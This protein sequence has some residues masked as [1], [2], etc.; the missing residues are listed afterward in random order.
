M[1]NSYQEQVN[2]AEQAINQI[3]TK[4]DVLDKKI[5]GL[6][7]NLR[8]VGKALT[9]SGQSDQLKKQ[10]EQIKLLNTQLQKQEEQTKKLSEAEKKSDQLKKRRE[11]QIKRESDL[12]ERLHRQKVREEKENFNN[13]VKAA[14]ARKKLTSEEKKS[15]E[16]N[17][18]LIRSQ[19]NLKRAYVRLIN[20]QNNAKNKLRDLIVTGKKATQTQR[21]H[22]REVK[23]AQR[24]FDRYTRKLN[25]ANKATS[26][27]SKNGLGRML[28]GFRNLVGGFGIILGISLLR[29]FTRAVFENLKVLDKLN[30]SL[31]AVI[32]NEGELMRTRAFLMD[33]SIRFGAELVSTTERYIK[34]QVAARQSG[35][36]LQKTEGIFRTM[37]KASAVL[38]LKTDELTGIYLALE[39]M[40]SKGKVTTEELRRQL[41]ERLPGAF[42]IMA[43]AVG[44]TTAE[45]DKMLKKGEI[46]SAEVLP[47]FAREV[48]K[49]LGIETVKKVV[50]LQTSVT[51]LTSSWQMLIE[52]LRSGQAWISGVLIFSFQMV[53]RTLRDIGR[54]MIGEEQFASNN[55][56][57]K[58]FKSLQESNIGLQVVE[59][60]L[61]TTKKKLEALQETDA[62]S[63][64]L[65][66][67]KGTIRALEAYVELINDRAKA[68]KALRDQLINS[69]VLKDKTI[70]LERLEAMTTDELRA[71]LVKLNEERTKG[72][73]I[74]KGSLTFLEKNLSS[75]K[76]EQK[77][78]SRN[79]KEWESYSEAILLAEMAIINFKTAI[80]GVSEIEL[81]LEN[82]DFD[83]IS[84]E[85]E[86]FFDDWEN[87]QERA[88]ELA[89]FL[90]ENFEE[91][92]ESIQNNFFDDAGFSR[93]NELFFQAQENGETMFTNLLT[94]AETSGEK[95]AVIFS[96]MAQVAQEAFAFINQAQQQQFDNQFERLEIERDVALQFAGESA[97]A[98]EEIERQ[99]EDRRKAI[100]Q[101][102]AKAQKDS[103]MFN[104]SINTAQAVV[105][106]LTSTPPNIPL[107]IL[108]GIIGAAKL[109]IIASTKVPE[110]M[111]GTMSTPEG[112]AKVDERVPEVH[113]DKRG[114]IKSLGGDKP[115]YRYLS[116]GDKIYKSRE[117]YF[118]KE[119][120]H[121]FDS[122]GITPYS[123]MMS[124]GSPVVNISSGLSK[125]E[126]AKGIN[127]LQKTIESKEGISVN[128]NKNGM[129][130]FETKGGQRKEMLNNTLRLKG[131]DV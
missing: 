121:I 85:L 79:S 81:D 86:K 1:A 61:E 88:R 52:N 131:R 35:L 4:V 28:G 45:L 124:L 31:K 117:M 106:A 101:R 87:Q 90:K 27:F 102:Q 25:I 59:F 62:S 17:K 12:R 109:A 125:Q 105:A 5:L 91:F 115:N 63:A 30:F 89:K 122:N 69:I 77:R 123:E 26:N 72:I 3:I 98:R 58:L 67:L 99:Y 49:A 51:N 110:F 118:E 8:K 24:V 42:G 107:S 93:L 50:T 94:K 40:L 74:L 78:L 126:F 2:Q 82:L 18:R 80:D 104:T 21:Q 14:R 56:F 84:N 68:E 53:A 76:S 66:T 73:L 43:D 36:S 119:L 127:R 11:A 129:K 47:K 96:S 65:G 108:V 100:Q 16:S 71:L 23:K 75:L 19:Q 70:S 112:W 41:G 64:E 10:S 48:E 57:A 9:P 46:L 38:G 111:S 54:L 114:K 20:K 34:F 6:I 15:E 92:F 39:Q 120:K 95:F 29:D 32:K 128:I 55:I 103:A 116:A 130:I 60:R 33:I 44:V 7:A 113:T 97:T 83:K 13:L 37:T 22:N